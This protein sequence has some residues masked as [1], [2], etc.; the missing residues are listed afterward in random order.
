MQDE[1]LA[2]PADSCETTGE[3]EGDT[4]DMSSKT[5]PNLSQNTPRKAT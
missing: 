5:T 4:W 3:H 2:V 1:E